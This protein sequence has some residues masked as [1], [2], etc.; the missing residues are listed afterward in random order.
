MS[1]NKT[2]AI[3]SWISF[4]TS[5]AIQSSEEGDS[6]KELQRY[7]RKTKKTPN[8]QCRSQRQRSKLVAQS[9][10]QDLASSIVL[11]TSARAKR[12]FLETR[13]CLQFR[14]RRQSPVPPCANHQSAAPITRV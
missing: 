6:L 1:L 14:P 13:T 9:S 12:E 8:V 10:I 11:V 5:A 3:S 7:I 2:W 4:L